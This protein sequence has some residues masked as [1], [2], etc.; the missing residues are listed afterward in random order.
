MVVR[1]FRD[2]DPNIEIVQANDGQTGI[3][4]IGEREFDC[5]LLDYHLPDL[6][7]LKILEWLQGEEEM[8]QVPV[9]ML[10]GEENVTLAV[11]SMKNGACDFLVKGS[12]SRFREFLPASIERAMSRQRLIKEKEKATA[13]NFAK[14]EFLSHMSH[15]LR[16]PLN[17]IIGFSGAIKS[18]TFGP[19]GHEKYKEY[20]DDI[21][22]S[23]EHLL[24]I[25]NDILE[26]T[27]IEA[28]K[29]ELQKQDLDI[30]EL[31]KES[32]HMVEGS[33]Q[34]SAASLICNIPEKHIPLIADRMLIKKILINIL[35]NAVKFTPENG[36]VSI[37]MEDR[38]ETIAIIVEDTGIGISPEDIPLIVEPFVQA[39]RKRMKVQEGTGLGLPL[40]KKFAEMHDGNL[41]IESE[42]GK[43]TKVTIVLPRQT[44]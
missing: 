16:T 22:K 36:T 8:P 14:V 2:Y 15:E 34:F 32:I 43:G 29:I 10:T 17:A 5:V 9:I 1:A 12:D 27:K 19:L 4:L 24:A 37:S 28:N 21:S 39:G 40:S 18:E 25:I 26:L 44:I 33:A 30:L 38:G 7:G 41:E 6:D 11:E 3:N 13:A 35:N 23:G 42:V 31:I 20:V